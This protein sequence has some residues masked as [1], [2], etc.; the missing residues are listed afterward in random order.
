MNVFIL[1]A[2]G[3]WGVACFLSPSIPRET[4]FLFLFFVL[5]CTKVATGSVLGDKAGL[6]GGGAPSARFSL[7]STVLASVKRQCSL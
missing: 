4:T 2:L 7:V 6:G 3:K 1:P 5:F